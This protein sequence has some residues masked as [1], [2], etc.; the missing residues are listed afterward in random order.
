MQHTLNILHNYINTY[1]HIHIR[2]KQTSIKSEGK[3]S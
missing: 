3:Q 1:E 2:H